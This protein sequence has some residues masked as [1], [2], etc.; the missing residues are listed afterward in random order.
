MKYASDTQDTAVQ[1]LKEV[2]V[3]DNR[4]HQE[5][6][7]K[8]ILAKS[9]RVVA[10]GLRQGAVR[11]PAATRARSC[12]THTLTQIIV[13]YTFIYIP[14]NEIEDIRNMLQHIESS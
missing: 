3:V 9:P 4:E 1:G 14:I 6:Y 5:V 13:N 7:V 11:R 2:S 8:V 10:P 12:P